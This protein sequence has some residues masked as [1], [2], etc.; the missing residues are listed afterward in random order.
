MYQTAGFAKDENE[1]MY[2]VKSLPNGSSE[3]AVLETLLA[4]PSPR[5]HTLPVTF[6]PC[7]NTTVTLSKQFLQ[8]W[9]AENWVEFDKFLRLFRDIMEVRALSSSS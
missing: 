5:N 4:A 7:A 9:Y 2:V 3:L 1:V 8:T 6:I